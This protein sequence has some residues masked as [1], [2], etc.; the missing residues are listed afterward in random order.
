[1]STRFS[2]PKFI[3]NDFQRSETVEALETVNDFKGPFSTEMHNIIG[4]SNLETC[5][6][7][8]FWNPHEKPYFESGQLLGGMFCFI[9]SI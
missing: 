7:S 5:N 9:H 2:N 1:M 3:F 6:K 4:S 8:N